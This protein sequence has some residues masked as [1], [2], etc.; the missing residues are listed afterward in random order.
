MILAI[1]T[2]YKLGWTHLIKLQVVVAPYVVIRSAEPTKMY[3]TIPA[4]IGERNQK[5]IR[6]LGFGWVLSP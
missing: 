3:T 5:S 4:S 6:Q 1:G 2:K